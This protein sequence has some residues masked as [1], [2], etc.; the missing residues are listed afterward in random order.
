MVQ[1]PRDDIVVA[2][3]PPGPVPGIVVGGVFVTQPPERRERI[4]AEGFA[5]E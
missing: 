5:L 1:E 3:E 4:Q 2:G